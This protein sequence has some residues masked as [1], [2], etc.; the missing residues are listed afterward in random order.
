MRFRAFLVLILGLSLFALFPKKSGTRQAPH[1]S[2]AVQVPR[3]EIEPVTEKTKPMPPS[4][5]NAV[6][7]DASE[8]CE[9]M[10]A[11]NDD[12]IPILNSVYE[13]LKDR[14]P[15]EYEELLRPDG[16]FAQDTEG[17]RQTQI[18][19]FIASLYQAGLMSPARGEPDLHAAWT[20]LDR[21]H[22]EDPENAAYSLFRLSVEQQLG[23]GTPQIQATLEE[24]ARATKFDTLY[25]TFMR[26][27][28]TAAVKSQ[29]PLTY[30]LTISFLSRLPAPDYNQLQHQVGAILESVPDVRDHLAG[31]LTQPALNAAKSHLLFGYNVLEYSMGRWLS[32]TYLPRLEELE[33]QK[34][35]PSLEW[36][37]FTFDVSKCG[38]ANF[39]ESREKLQYLMDSI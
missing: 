11:V 3:P 1:D 13:K 7:T 14:V 4:S 29:D 30:L 5:N 20:E 35:K 9:A 26:E 31:L 27:V 28:H 12:S 15:A 36:D 39:A 16:P 38:P 2:L 10:R 23:M 32:D 33:S 18:G 22:W 25:T 6:L 24:L 17:Y 37:Q 8:F 21:L 19:R 34:Q